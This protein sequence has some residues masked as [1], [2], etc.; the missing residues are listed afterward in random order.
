[1]S[2]KEKLLEENNLMLRAI[3]KSLSIQTKDSIGGTL[4]PDDDEG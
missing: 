4:P 1:M 2:K 3:M